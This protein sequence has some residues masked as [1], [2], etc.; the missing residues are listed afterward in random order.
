MRVSRA[1]CERAARVDATMPDVPAK[2]LAPPTGGPA[3]R[4]PR[5]RGKRK[6]GV[7]KAKADRAKPSDAAD[8]DFDSRDGTSDASDG[9][10]PESEDE[11]DDGY[12]KG[13]YH[14]VRV[15]DT[16]KDGR[17]VVL[18]KLGWGHFSTCWLCDDTATGAKVALK[19]QKSAQH[20]TEAAMD[21]IKRSSERSRTCAP[22][23]GGRGP[24]PATATPPSPGAQLALGHVRA[25]R[26]GGWERSGGFRGGGFVR[27]GAAPGR[28]EG[29]AAA[30]QLRAQRT[31]RDAR[32]HDVRGAGG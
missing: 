3:A 11:G 23:I 22:S 19:V 9:S 4:K 17:Y 12:R 31:E 5:K 18:E 20:Y 14:P 6:G 27:A 2:F 8:S 16:Y 7:T 10:G 26:G 21:E 13:G 24:R 28:R 15:G 32:V 1:S 25:G 30:G 29:C